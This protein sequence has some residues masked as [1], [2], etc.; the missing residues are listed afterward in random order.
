MMN[1]GV[2]HIHIL[3]AMQRINLTWIFLSLNFSFRPP[4]GDLGVSYVSQ[5]F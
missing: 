3:K 2:L 5:Y 4:A 1:H